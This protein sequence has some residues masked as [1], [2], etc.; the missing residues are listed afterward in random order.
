MISNN[1]SP[2][3]MIVNNKFQTKISDI[4]EEEIHREKIFTDIEKH[5]DLHSIDLSKS[6][7]EI[8]IDF[9]KDN[10]NSLVNNI[11]S[12]AKLGLN[13]DFQ[14]TCSYNS[15]PESNFPYT[16]IDSLE[17]CTSGSNDELDFKSFN[18]NLFDNNKQN[19]FSFDN[20]SKP[21]NTIFFNDTFF[22]S[23]IEKMMS[24]SNNTNNEHQDESFDSTINNK[25]IEKSQRNKINETSIVHSSFEDHNKT[26]NI[27]KISKN[28][29]PR[30]NK[31]DVTNS[32]EKKLL[33]CFSILR[34]NYLSLC[35]SYNN[36]LDELES[37]EIEKNMFTS[38]CYEM[39][40]D[41][42]Q[43]QFE[44]ERLLLEREDMKSIL[45]GLLHEVTTLRVES[46]KR[47]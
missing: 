1:D 15:S 25:K 30:H 19:E 42:K 12:D 47:N 4:Q 32:R 9:K 34:T 24:I 17:S 3:N 29:I 22:D 8:D 6:Q 18:D 28:H 14:R 10:G 21:N 38:K 7:L 27:S 23:E 45:D 26:N 13:E 43:W 46:N 35:D 33:K 37:T 36:L 5:I 16:P 40:K 11:A 20:D 44:K 31:S 41:K 39:E 2:L